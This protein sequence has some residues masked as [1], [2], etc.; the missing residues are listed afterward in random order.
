MKILK[1]D[2]DAGNITVVCDEPEDMWHLYNLI[3]DGDIVTMKTYRKV[4]TESS[5]GSTKS[6]KVR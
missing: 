6:K 4:I 3:Y 5:T 2:M 1:R